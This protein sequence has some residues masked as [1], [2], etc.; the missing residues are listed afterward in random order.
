[1]EEPHER[2]GPIEKGEKGWPIN[3]FGVVA[4]LVFISI[5]GF[6]II[7]PLMSPKSGGINDQQSNPGGQII[8]PSAGQIIKGDRLSIELSPDEPSK[9]SKIQFWVKTYADNKW[10]MIGEVSTSP[11]K[12]DWQIPP[13]F[14]NKAI[15]ITTHIIT[16]DGSDI[17]DPGGWREG[18]VLLSESQ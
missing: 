16:T 6:L 13:D 10:Q 14:Q 17:K 5:I 3:P 1:M 11:F 18:I 12:L 8:S 15:A 9:V 7:K 2:R 4:L